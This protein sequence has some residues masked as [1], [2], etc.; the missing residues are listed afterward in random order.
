[1]RAQMLRQPL[2]DTGNADVPADMPRQLALGQPEVAEHAGNESAIVVA[3]E[4]KRRP[5]GGIKFADRGNILGCEEYLSVAGVVQD[6]IPKTLPIEAA[7]R[8]GNEQGSI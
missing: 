7:Y 2:G 1:M 3:G 5:S 4:E 6:M 8:P